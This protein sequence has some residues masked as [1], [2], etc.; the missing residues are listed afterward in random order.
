MVAFRTRIR[1]SAIALVLILLTAF[2]ILIYTGLA[3]LL[4][5]HVD[6]E[7]PTLADQE[8][9]KGH[10]HPSRASVSNPREHRTDRRSTDRSRRVEEA[11]GGFFRLAVTPRATALPVRP[12]F[13]AV[14]PI[15]RRRA[16]RDHTAA[17]T[18]RFAS[19]QHKSLARPVRGAAGGVQAWPEHLDDA[20][21]RNAWVA[22]EEAGGSPSS[23]A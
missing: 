22:A 21:L 14:D 20:E 2:S 15:R 16:S 7:L 18:G 19:R 6:R 17:L 4:A 10:L 23:S 13:L 8:A 3:T 5:Q 9:A 11:F 1:H 12:E